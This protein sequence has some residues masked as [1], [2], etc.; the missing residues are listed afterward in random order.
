MLQ[1]LDIISWRMPPKSYYSKL[2]GDVGDDPFQHVE[3]VL[4][5]SG[6]D[7]R[8]NVDTNG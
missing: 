8:R 5:V 1:E 4:Y 3:T 7:Y 2:L 6:A